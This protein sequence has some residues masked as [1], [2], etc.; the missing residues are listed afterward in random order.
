MA[1]FHISV[2]SLMKESIE[3][4]LHNCAAI[5]AA[6][7]SVGQKWKQI[8]VSTNATKRNSLAPDDSFCVTPA[9]YLQSSLRM[10]CAVSLGWN[11]CPI[12]V[13]SENSHRVQP[14]HAFTSRAC[15][16]LREMSS[17]PECCPWRVLFCLSAWQF[18]SKLNFRTNIMTCSVFTVCF[19]H[20]LSHGQLVIM[21]RE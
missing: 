19:M 20:F 1:C 12:E 6:F 18:P 15:Q 10:C 2:Q 21:G 3:A 4:A 9:T 5:L 8:T 11:S 7:P 16:M 13:C 14:S 17:K